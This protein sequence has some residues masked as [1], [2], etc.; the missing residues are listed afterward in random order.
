MSIKIISGSE[1]LPLQVEEGRSA[2]L[3]KE[4]FVK[5]IQEFNSK[6][7][8][9]EF[10]VKFDENYVSYKFDIYNVYVHIS[11]LDKFT[12][13]FRFYIEGNQIKYDNLINICIM[14]KDASDEF[15]SVLQDN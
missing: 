4:A 10:I 15:R 5:E 1:W 8:F 2:K 11:I 9:T 12:E 6:I 13:K 7:F 3:K 14:V